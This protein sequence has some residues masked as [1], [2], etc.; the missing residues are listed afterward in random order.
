[1]NSL[2]KPL[3]VTDP[4]S[5]YREGHP[6]ITFITFRFTPSFEQKM[7]AASV[8]ITFDKPGEVVL[9]TRDLDIVR[10][11]D[12]YGNVI[13]YELGQS[14]KL[15]GAPLTFTVHGTDGLCLV[16]IFYATSPN[17]SGLQWLTAEQTS[18]GKFPF[19]FTQFQAIHARS[20]FPCQDTPMVRFNYEMYLTVPSSLRGLAGANEWLGQTTV[21][22]KNLVCEKWRM[23]NPIPS[24]LVAFVVGLVEEHKFEAR[25]SVW[26]EPTMLSAA[27]K[28]FAKL[29]QVMHAAEKRFGPYRWGTFSLLVM[30]RAFAYGGMENPH[31]T[32]LSPALVSGDGSG[33]SVAIHELMHFWFGNLITNAT[34]RDFSLNEGW[35]CYAEFKIIADVLGISEA[36]LRQCLL[37]QEC[38]RDIRERFLG[39]PLL[40]SLAPDLFGINP[41]EIFSRVPYKKGSHFLLTLEAEIGEKNMNML[42][43]Q[44][45]AEF[46]W[47]S[48]TVSQFLDFL[49][50]RLPKGTLEKIR[51][52]DWF[53]E[54]GT[55]SNACVIRSK[56][57]NQIERVVA[58]G[59]IPFSNET[60]GWSAPAWE[61]YL[62]SLPRTTFS[63]KLSALDKRFK[64]STAKNT[65]VR[66]AF[67]L[68]AVEC[69]YLVVY[70]TDIKKFLCEQGR[71]KYLL[72][73]YMELAKTKEGLEFG[74]SVFKTARVGYQG[75]VV[76]HMEK[77]LKIAA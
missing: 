45:I 43:R 58:T 5:H 23:T 38:D 10:V 59:T 9:D 36:K 72:P 4:H 76:D 3:F 47:K 44:Y 34:Q 31:L 41:D 55:P 35:T 12:G 65:E 61:Y 26:A 67:L 68:L 63:N 18:D 73:L 57:V 19:L 39:H 1:M 40:T 77:V 46:A 70:E 51:A 25:C 27:A 74:R 66:W 53:Y 69:G 13:K 28:E 22:N 49:A 29:P 8:A 60:K 33:L 56:V 24:Y 6:R 52:W 64:L 2:P 16:R 15:L 42:S 11:E 30:P 48:V 50:R 7:I 62:A 20:V 21:L 37:G 54:A 71:K 32:N 14:D 75:P 17:A